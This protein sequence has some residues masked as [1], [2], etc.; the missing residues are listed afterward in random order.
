MQQHLF[1]LDRFEFLSLFAG[2]DIQETPFPFI[3]SLLLQ[4]HT[5][6]MPNLLN[7]Y[8]T[9]IEEASFCRLTMGSNTL[10][11]YPMRRG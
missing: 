5:R 2:Q 11:R 4:V 3:K 10:E 8:N 6:K 1:N 7:T 9:Y